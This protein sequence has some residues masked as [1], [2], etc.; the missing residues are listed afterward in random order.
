M[1]NE[2]QAEKKSEQD[3]QHQDAPVKPDAETLNT[4]DPQENM[5]GP[6]SSLMNGA[7]D[8]IENQDDS[9]EAADRKREKNM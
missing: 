6:L 2:N 3:Q 5:E 8:K 4:T 1:N 9:K 7:K